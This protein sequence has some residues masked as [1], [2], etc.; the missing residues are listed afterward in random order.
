M[1]YVLRWFDLGPG[2]H[3]TL[4]ISP[5]GVALAPRNFGR[6]WGF[7]WVGRRGWDVGSGSVIWLEVAAVRSAAAS[8]APSSCMA[9]KAYGACPLL[10]PRPQRSEVPT[11]APGIF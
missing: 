10:Y 2:G 5:G 3:F 6:G 9:E 1:G 11:L 7:V 4:P 8:A